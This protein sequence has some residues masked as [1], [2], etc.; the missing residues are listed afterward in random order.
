M[1]EVQRAIEL[2]G[3]PED[4]VSAEAPAVIQFGD[5]LQYVRGDIYNAVVAQAW[6]PGPWPKVEDVDALM[7]QVEDERRKLKGGDDV[8]SR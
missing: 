1:D 2:G 4:E 6:S 3:E 7:K 8:D 5:E